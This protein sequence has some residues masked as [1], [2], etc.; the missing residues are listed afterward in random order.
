MIGVIA[1]PKL[2][3]APSTVEVIVPYGDV[4]NQMLVWKVIPLMTAVTV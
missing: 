2:S 3:A 4:D 1:S